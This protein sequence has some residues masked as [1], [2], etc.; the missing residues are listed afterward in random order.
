[1]NSRFFVILLLIVVTYQVWGEQVATDSPAVQIQT[2]IPENDP[3]LA[4]NKE[5]PAV[6]KVKP[7]SLEKHFGGRFRSF[8]ETA[9]ADLA[10]HSTVIY[11]GRNNNEGRDN[12]GKS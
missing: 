1:M 9:P 11:E 5:T 6:S 12:E 7:A 10:A 4:P 8:A 2:A 3:A